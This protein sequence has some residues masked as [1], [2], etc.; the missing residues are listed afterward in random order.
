MASTIRI[1]RSATSGNPSTLA[2]GELAYSSLADNGSNGGDRLYVGHGTE[3]NGDA[4]THEVIGGKYFTEK[5]DHALGTL[6]SNSAILVDGDMKIDQIK[7]DHITIDSDR[8]STNGGT[9]KPIVLAPDGGII[10]VNQSRIINVTTPTGDSDAANKVYVDTQITANNNAQNLAYRADA[11]AT[12]GQLNITLDTLKI[13]GMS[14]ITTTATTSADSD[15]I[16]VDLDDT[17]VTPG[18]YGSATA[19]P[20]FTVDQQGRLTAAGTANVA[21]TLSTSGET[22]T[23]TVDLLTQTLAFTAGEGITTTAS[24]QGVTIEGED[25]TD[26]NKGIASFDATDFTVT[27]GNVVVNPTTIGTTEVNPGATTTAIAGMTQLDVD[28]IRLNG[29]TIS[30]TDSANSVMI[31]DPGN[32]G[33]TSGRMIILGDLQV[34][35]TTT[36]INSTTL[37][38]DDI[39]LTLASG[40][41]DSAAANNAGITIEGP[42]HATMKYNASTDHFDFGLG[43]NIPA[44]RE[45]SVGGVG[46]LEFIH[47]DW[48]TNVFLAGE[49]IDITYDDANDNIT[50]A[51]EIATSSNAGV[52]SFDATEFSV[53]GAGAVTIAEINGGTY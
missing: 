45:F 2:A 44:T 21:T 29:S 31:M 11:G 49:G 13:K 50:F 12:S 7:V 48:A 47:D 37:D 14:G 53:T 10:D 43:I 27:S 25:A 52:A 4:A 8:I 9:S 16:E 39:N 32:N 26:T 28:N 20:T 34:D 41:A 17:A 46:L 23:G 51:A 35:G 24:G 30:T 36:T 38:V 40:A 18:S 6:T 5:L 1:K 42:N 33:T 19:V 3:T 22:G 15:V